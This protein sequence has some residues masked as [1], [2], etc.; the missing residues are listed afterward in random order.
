MTKAI[1]FIRSLFPFTHEGRQTLVYVALSWAAPVICAMLLWSMSRI[2]TFPGAAAD[3]RLARFADLAD[4]I[5]WGLLIILI[6]YAC[7][8]SIRAIK[9]GKDGFSAESRDDDAPAAA[10]AVADA[11]Q[12]TADV[13]K[14]EVK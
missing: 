14:D 3:Q 5:S 9:I 10:Q 6:A 4:R 11:A 13:I 12:E 8:V 7:F 2:E 1:A